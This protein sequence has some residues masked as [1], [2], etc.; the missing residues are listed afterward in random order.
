MAGSGHSP[1]AV[2]VGSGPNGLAAAITL[3][4]AGFSVQVREAALTAGGGTRSEPLTLPGFVHDVCSAAH[5]LGAASPFFR[6]LPLEEHGLRWIHS[7]AALAHPLDDGSAVM[8]WRD[9]DRT[10]DGLGVDARSY[11]ALMGPLVAHWEELFEETL[12]PL[13]R[14]PRHPLL[15]ARFGFWALASASLLA[16]VR[17]RGER[18]RA[19]FAGIAAHSSTPLSWTGSAAVGLTLGIAGH[20]V[21]WPIAEGGSGSIARALLKCLGGLGG[22]VVT[23][24]PVRSVDELEG[25]RLVLLDLAPCQVLRL[26]GHRLPERYRRVLS[27]YRQGP[28]VF[29]VDWALGGPIPWTASECREAATVHLGGR[30][31]EIMESERLPVTGLA[32]RRPFVLLTQPSLFDPTRAPP[33]RHT[34]WAYCHVPNGFAEDVLARIEDQIERFAPGFRALILARH[35]MTPA[36]LERHNANLVGGDISGG[37]A[38]LGQL[39]WR[40]TAGPDPYR[41]PAPGIFVC[42]ASTPP[43]PGAHGLCGYWAARSALRAIGARQSRKRPVARLF[44]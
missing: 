39:L 35:V 43:G 13:A 19:L 5:P 16:R 1:D 25:A 12:R 26:A 18:A 4:R 21:G 11:R 8:L 15:L 32:P 20:A 17:F 34:S 44:R 22:E 38:S 42:S 27:R 29:K 9:L 7:A 31:A 37:L 28:G 3:A 6:S 2:V 23:G 24:A 40:P 30:I 14:P 10:A 33:G 41:T 36:D